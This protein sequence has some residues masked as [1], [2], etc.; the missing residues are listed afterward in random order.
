MLHT[1]KFIFFRL[2]L[3]LIVFDLISCSE[4]ETVFELKA[5]QQKWNNN[6]LKWQENEL[7]VLE[8]GE[9]YYR[10]NCSACHLVNGLGQNSLGAPGFKNNPLMKRNPKQHIYIIMLGKDI[11][12]AYAELL[13]DEVIAAIVS[14]EK[15]AWGNNTGVIVSSAQ[16]NEIRTKIN[17]NKSR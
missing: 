2:F 12:P 10:I 6:G 4:K 17:N 7:R 5:A 8:S 16:I 15:N 13:S 11:M 14:Y 3:L 9:H 1:N